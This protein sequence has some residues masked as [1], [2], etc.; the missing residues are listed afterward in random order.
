MSDEEDWRGRTGWGGAGAWAGLKRR[1]RGLGKVKEFISLLSPQLGV[2]MRRKERGLICSRRG[3]AGFANL[4]YF[5]AREGTETERY[6]K[7]S[8]RCDAKS[9]AQVWLLQKNTMPVFVVRSPFSRVTELTARPSHRLQSVDWGQRRVEG[10]KERE[11]T[12]AWSF[13][14][15][16]AGRACEPRP[17]SRSAVQ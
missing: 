2:A 17:G 5:S 6:R 8:R 10:G 11:G 7:C 14:A 3:R 1:L 13:L 9:K 4:F 16:D 15:R 12:N